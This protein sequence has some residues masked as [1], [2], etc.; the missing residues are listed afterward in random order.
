MA[1]PPHSEFEACPRSR[2][3]E[4][5]TNAMFNCINC[6]AELRGNVSIAQSLHYKRSD[7][8]FPL[9][10]PRQSTHLPNRDSCRGS[11]SRQLHGQGSGSGRLRKQ[12]HGANHHQVVIVGDDAGLPVNVD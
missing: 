1:K 11:R 2:F 8:P 6:Y 10:E 12:Q 9:R 3:V 5:G 4:N 7:A